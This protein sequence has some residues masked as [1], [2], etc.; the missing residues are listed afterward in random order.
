M[1]AKQPTLF[2]MSRVS[3]ATTPQKRRWIA[4][5]GIA[6]LLLLFI[7][8]VGGFLY[9]YISRFESVSGTSVASLISQVQAAQV[10]DPFG[11]DD[12]VHLLVVG[13][14]EIRNQREGSLLTD[15]IM[16][17]SVHRSGKVTLF[18][19]PRD[20]WID[21]LKTKVNALYYYG[22]ESEDTT[23]KELLKT[24]I[25]DFT[26]VEIDYV[27]V[28]TMETVEALVNAMGGIEVDVQRSFIDN[29]FPR[30]G[31]DISSSDPDVL[32]ETVTFDVGRHLFSG[33]TALKFMRSRQSEDSIEGTDEARIARQ[34][35]VVQSMLSKMRE[36]GVWKD[37]E[38]AGNIYKTWQNTVQTEM[39]DA[40]LAGII[41]NMK[42]RSIEIHSTA[43]PISD[44]EQEGIL[45]VPPISKYHQWVYEPEDPSW[46]QLKEWVQEQ[47]E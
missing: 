21:S 3:L 1:E 23:G 17:V 18:S 20:L 40:D 41:L 32:Y 5:Y 22:E 16:V 25:T 2:R 7:G 36:I 44:A 27:M 37:P 19:I 26:Q 38:K 11:K 6:G 13:L 47:L 8:V 30:N 15:T 28:F 14:D 9:W 42:A 24:V 46:R 35:L 34:Q 29:K 12:Y 10:S 33:E 4:L 39:T 31:V 45:V 43:I